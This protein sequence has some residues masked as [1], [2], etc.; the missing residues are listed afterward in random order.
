MSR[1]GG[2]FG[3]PDR[4]PAAV[5]LA[6]VVLLAGC[7][8]V[9]LPGE[10]PQT[11]TATDAPV[12]TATPT[13]T[14]TPAPTATPTWTAPAPPNR[15]TEVKGEDERISEVAFVDREASGEGYSS[16][17]LR[18]HADTTMEGVDPPDHGSPGGEPYFLVFVDGELVTRT[19]I[20]VQEVN[21]EFDVGV[22]EAAL[23]QFEA[24]TLEVDVVLMDEDSEYDDRYGTWSGTIEYVPD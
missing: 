21:G 24:G 18:V 4:S 22:K 7:S 13:A 1:L 17:D 12:S 23:E 5:A 11:P 2:V 10:G 14:A 9:V 19:K 6:L 16:F 3:M 20:V 15:P 8:T